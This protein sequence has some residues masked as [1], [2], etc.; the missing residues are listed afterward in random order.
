M[1]SIFTVTLLF[2]FSMSVFSQE[3]QVKINHEGKDFSMLKHAWKAQWITHPTESTLDYGVFNFRKNFEIKSLPKEFIIYVSAD[4][5][6]RLYVNGVYIVNGPSIG[7]INN[8]RYETIDIA[9]HLKPGKN[10]IA[11]EVDNFGEYRRAAQQTFQTAFILQAET[12]TGLDINTGTSPWKV[13]KN[14]AYHCIPFTSDS[15]RAYYSAG[16]GELITAEDYPWGW[17]ETN[18][19]D[20]NWLSPKAGTVEFAVGKGF[21]Y[22]STWF[23]VPRQIPFMRESE[24]RFNSI[25]RVV[26]EAS[27][28][29]FI[30][31]GVSATIP[32]NTK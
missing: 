30:Q 32:A 14:K 5:R 8:Y 15:L 2:I 11:A 23:L 17:N 26:P 16:P 21:L 25:A 27:I 7:D 3:S 24:E 9:A 4:N 13:I 29:P 20:K 31:L 10:V 6:Y 12:D 1:K 28:A 18:Y 22:G 19:D